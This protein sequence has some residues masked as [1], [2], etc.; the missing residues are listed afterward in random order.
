M[1]IRNHIRFALFGFSL[2]LPTH[3]LA[4]EMDVPGTMDALLTMD[5]EQLTD[6]EVSLATGSLKPVRLAPAVASVIT[7][8]QIEQMGATTLDQVLET[9]PGLHVEP[10]GTA[11]LGST[12]SIRGIHTTTNPHVLLLINSLPFTNN[13]QGGKPIPFTLPVAMISRVE[14]IRGPG[15]ALHGADAFAGVINVV[16]KNSHEIDGTKTGV[17]YGSFNTNDVWLQHGASAEGWDLAF[18]ME[19]LKTEG[20]KDRI[21][22]QDYLHAAGAAHLSNAPGPLDSSFEVLDTHL[23]LRKDNWN[24]HLN[25]NLFKTTLGLGSLQVVTNDNIGDRVNWMTDLAYENNDLLRD[26]QLNGRLYYSYR[27]VDNF[28]QLLPPAFRNM[29]GNPIGTNHNGGIEWSGLYKG[30]LDHKL[31]LGVGWANKEF[32]P[33]QYKNFGPAAGDNQFGEIVHVSDPN[34]IYISDS[35]RQLIFGLIQDEWSLAKGWDLTAGIRY[36][37]Y[38]DFG[39]TTNPRVALVWETRYDL[40]TKLLYGQAFRAPSFGEQGVKNNPQTIGNPDINPEEIETLE[41]AMDYQPTTNLRLV[42]SIYTYEAKELIELTGPLPQPYTNVG[43]QEG[44]GFELEMI[45]QVVEKLKLTANYALQSSKYKET[46]SRVPDA[47]GQQFYL[48]P[49]WT[50]M[51]DWSLDGQY[52][53]VGD[54]RRALD[55]PRDDIDDYSLVNLT[56]RRKNIAK[57]WDVALAVRNVFDEIGRIPSPYAPGVPEGAYVPNDYPMEGR[58]VWGEVRYSF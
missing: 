27:H 36:D 4:A 37:E 16:T 38:S 52:T 46:D 51:Q 30:L 54:R 33:D 50:F 7:A 41:L 23:N 11:F 44:Q 47:P 55:D 24:Y 19:W 53:W 48:N 28:L 10:S 12:W 6:L 22:D 2:L 29:Q 40:I 34:H 5:L 17:R 14:V 31:R 57:Y 25:L 15:S 20:D 9:V 21:I 1:T 35:N 43:E 42:A 18:G 8:E 56:L 32:E 45:W 39:S 26:W 49:H 58:A 13:Q 3:S